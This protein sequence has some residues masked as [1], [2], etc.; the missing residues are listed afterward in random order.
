MIIGILDEEILCPVCSVRKRFKT[1]F[2][3]CARCDWQAQRRSYLFESAFDRLLV[4][5]FRDSRV[6]GLAPL[7]FRKRQ[8]SLL[9]VIPL[10][11]LI[12]HVFFSYAS[13]RVCD[14]ES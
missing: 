13:F 14:V 3:C 4:Q 6:F 12:E 9:A 5:N 2:F 7:A 8:R 10:L 11:Y 1:V